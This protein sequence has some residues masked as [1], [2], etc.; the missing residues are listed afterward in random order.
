MKP[1]AVLLA[2][3]WAVTTFTDI[4]SL[5]Y[6]QH[7]LF[8]VKGLGTPVLFTLCLAGCVELAWGW[9]LAR[10]APGRWRATYRAT[11]AMGVFYV[12]LKDF[13]DLLGVP[14]MAGEPNLLQIGLD[15]LPYLLF[16]V[17]VV[18]L[19]HEKEKS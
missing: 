5:A 3:L 17:P 12:L 9:R 19:V 11:L 8:V 6:A 15:F 1:Y 7:F 16:A 10:L 14:A 4:W 2:V 13:G 18:I